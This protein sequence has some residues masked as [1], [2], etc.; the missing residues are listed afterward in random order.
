V[1]TIVYIDGFNLYYGALKGTPHRWLDLQKLFQLMFPNND[2][3]AIKY[4]TALV[5]S[6]PNDPQ[7]DVRQQVY[8]RALATT[9]TVQV[10]LGHFL[11]HKTRMANANPP[12][13]TVEVIKTEEKGSDVNLATHLVHD[14]HMKRFDVALVVSND[15]DL[16]PAIKIVRGELGLKVG[17]VNPQ[18][19]PSREL[20]GQC[21]FMRPIRP[22]TLDKAHFPASMTDAKGAFTK[23]P[24]W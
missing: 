15:S 5:K 18:P 1:K 10:H 23:P 19:R 22:G 17:F 6:R 24:S 14:A 20:S 12:P 9:L 21:D 4:F 16:V 8:L 7:C 13:A 2:V 3:L 11:S